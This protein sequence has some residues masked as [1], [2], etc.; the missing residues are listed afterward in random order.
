MLLIPLPQPL[1]R[2][3]VGKAL[4]GT[5]QARSLVTLLH[6]HIGDMVAL[7]TAACAGVGIV[8]L[9]TLMLREDLASGA[10]VSLLPSWAPP[11]QIIHAVYP[12]RRCLLPAVRTLLD[13]LAERF[14]ALEQVN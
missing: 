12:S 1:A 2:G 5:L 4:H 8:Q 3:L 7:R 14:G 10:L 13:H 11:R 6:V 9:P